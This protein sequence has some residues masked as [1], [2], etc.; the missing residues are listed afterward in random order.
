M[1]AHVPI[2][3]RS[4]STQL[5]TV[6]IA[7]FML[8]SLLSFGSAYFVMRNSLDAGFQDQIEQMMDGY[9]AIDD[10]GDL[11]ARL[12]AD[13]ASI[14]ADTVIL[15]F[16]SG[17]GA[18][19]SNVRSMPTVDD[20]RLM[21]D[22][23][24]HGDDLADSYIALGQRVVA[25]HLTIAVSREPIAE[26]GEIFLAILVMGFLPT[27]AIASLVG[28]L[29]A[30]R[31]QVSINAIRS[32]LA[33]LTRGDFSAR[34][35]D[36]PTGTED[37]RQIAHAVNDM[38]DAQQASIAALK[39]VSTDIAHDLKTPIQRMSVLLDRLEER[40]S[41]SG[42]QLEILDAARDETERMA[43]TFQALLEIAQIEGGS[44]R[45]RFEQLDLR[46]IVATFVDIYGPAAEETGHRLSFRSS[47]AGGFFIRGDGHLLGQVVANLIEN[48]MRH[49][50]AGGVIDIALARTP[51]GVLL[52]VSDN[53]PGIPEGER[54]NVLRRLYRLERSRKAPG[55]GLGLS[56][57]AAICDLH[58][59]ALDLADNAPGLSVRLTFPTASLSKGAA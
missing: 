40:T 4:F 58:D 48:A 31:V 35:P 34:V 30:G 11:A 59:A 49:V 1:T 46:C 3:H 10:K 44:V 27:L 32:V 53:G 41:L 26:M 50:P 29:V 45:E 25:G 56:L 51:K 47:D 18:V 6:L 54:T 13:A 12:S 39:Q 38:A 42:E 20:F 52:S 7:I 5:A 55:N 16:E 28:W 17:A 9:R 19:I 22:A 24:I 8:S 33:N 14:D 36:V 43:K 23:E 37:L 21:P 2:L 15:Y 57:V